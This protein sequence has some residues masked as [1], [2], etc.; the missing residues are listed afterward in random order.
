MKVHNQSFFFNF[1]LVELH[2]SL[3]SYGSVDLPEDFIHSSLTKLFVNNC[4][5][6]DWAHITKLGRAFPCLQML[7]VM[8]TRI[9]RLSS[10]KNF[11]EFPVLTVLNISKCQI[12]SW[13]ELD[14]FRLFPSLTNLRI[15]DL[16]L[17]EVG[18]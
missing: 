15:T 5:I 14:K 13:E 4:D 3:N 2:V 1:S 10:D 6:N 12:A 11:T 7:T 17:I 18:I 8:E 9:S 16:P